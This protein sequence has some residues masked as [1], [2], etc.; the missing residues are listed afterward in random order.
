MVGNLDTDDTRLLVDLVNTRYLGDQ[1]DVLAGPDAGT[2]LGE[3][4]G[5]Q[6]HLPS[7]GALAPLRDVR[8]GLRQLAIANNQ[9]S[10]DAAAVDRANKVLRHVPLV[11]RLDGSDVSADFNSPEPEDSAERIVAA[12]ARAYVTTRAAGAWPRVKACAEP[13]CRWAFLDLSR[14]GSRRWCFMSKCGNRAKG[15]AWR[16]RHADD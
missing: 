13:E 3:R 7:T 15:R 11:V 8:E 16:A 5:W 10:S 2:W 14:N 6:G 12:V 4:L 1:S 9:G